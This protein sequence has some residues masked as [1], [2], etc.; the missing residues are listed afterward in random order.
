MKVKLLGHLLGNNNGNFKWIVSAIAIGACIASCVPP[1]TQNPFAKTTPENRDGNSPQESTR[2][3]VPQ[4]NA[5]PQA[6]AAEPAN[7]AT[8]LPQPPAPTPVALVPHQIA[9]KAKKLSPAEEEK[10]KQRLAEQR[11]VNAATT[12]WLATVTSGRANAAEAVVKLYAPDALLLGTVS[13]QVRDTPQEIRDYFNYFTQLPRLSVSGYRPF[14]RVY[15]SVAINSGYYT[16]SYEK[17]GHTKVVP[18]RYTFVY[19]KVN[20]NWMITEHHSSALPKAPESL[21]PAVD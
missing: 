1:E 11:S 13:E 2:S 15:G 7:S 10:E 8:P 12:E 14:I 16:F 3:K 19:R 4:Q 20:G 21:K 17:E 6:K 5:S 9:P 18:A